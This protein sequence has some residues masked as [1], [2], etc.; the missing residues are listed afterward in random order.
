[1][2]WL[3]ALGVRLHNISKRSSGHFYEFIPL[4]L[5][6]PCFKASNFFFALAYRFNQRRLFRLRI[7]QGFLHREDLLIQLDSCFEQLCQIPQTHKGLYEIRCSLKRIQALTDGDE[8]NHEI[9]S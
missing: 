8:V 9:R 4:L 5:C 6:F 7:G 3:G 2:L 1:M